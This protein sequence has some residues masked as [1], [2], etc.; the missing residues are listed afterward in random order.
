MRLSQTFSETHRGRGHFSV[1]ISV[2]RLPPHVRMDLLSVPCLEHALS[3]SSASLI[4]HL[5]SAGAASVTVTG[6]WQ[7][8]SEE[9]QGSDVSPNVPSEAVALWI[10]G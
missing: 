1:L 5:T 3:P 10:T 2:P 6:G 7:R 8:L 4:M 9:G